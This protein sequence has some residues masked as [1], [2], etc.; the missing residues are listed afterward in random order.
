MVTHECWLKKYKNNQSSVCSVLT[1]YAWLNAEFIFHWSKWKKNLLVVALVVR[2]S[3]G[4][5]ATQPTVEERVC[6]REI[7]KVIHR[8]QHGEGLA[9]ENLACITQHP[10]FSDVCLSPHVLEVAYFQY[11][12]DHVPHQEEQSNRLLPWVK[13]NSKALFCACNLFLFIELL[14]MFKVDYY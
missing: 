13:N 5:C 11:E 14:T 7:P 4:F 6:C 9:G 2:C 1:N 12:Q 3:C 10:G 8:R